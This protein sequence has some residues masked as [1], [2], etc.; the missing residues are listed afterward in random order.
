MV[1]GERKSSSTRWASGQLP[2]PIFK[3]SVWSHGPSSGRAGLGPEAAV[4]TL[5]PREGSQPQSIM[6]WG[7]D[8]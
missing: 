7:G 6:G 8:L 5:P 1:L 3:D 2:D 4:Q